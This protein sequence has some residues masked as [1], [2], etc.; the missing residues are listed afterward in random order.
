MGGGGGGGEGSG[1]VNRGR[2]SVLPNIIYVQ[3]P[4]VMLG[5]EMK[6]CISG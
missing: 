3:V 4:C 2:A 5:K 1:Q 6:L